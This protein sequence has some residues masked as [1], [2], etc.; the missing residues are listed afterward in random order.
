MSNKDALDNLAHDVRNA[1]T[2]I[3]FVAQK[4]GQN[5]KEMNIQAKRMKNA[6]ERYEKEV[7]GCPYAGK[8]GAECKLCQRPNTKSTKKN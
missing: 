1:L 2:V 4:M 6:W 7:R 5:A 3:L 8:D